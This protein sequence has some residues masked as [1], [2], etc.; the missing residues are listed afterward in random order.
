MV[1]QERSVQSKA[2]I[3]L[4]RLSYLLDSVSPWTTSTRSSMLSLDN[5]IPLT[6]LSASL[7]DITWILRR[8]MVHWILVRCSMEIFMATVLP[9]SLRTLFVPVS[10][11]V[12]LITLMVSVKE[13]MNRVGGANW[14][15][16]H[17]V[18]GS[19]GLSDGSCLS[20]SELQAIYNP[21]DTITFEWDEFDNPI[22]NSNLMLF[23]NYG[24]TMQLT[25]LSCLTIKLYS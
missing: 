21:I 1:W 23:G 14:A 16:L 20:L 18:G 12:V 19:L 25:C 9:S 4:I 24:M 8:T 2:T 22:P 5:F 15:M 17:F 7:I 6:L 10:I 13:G 11:P 3:T